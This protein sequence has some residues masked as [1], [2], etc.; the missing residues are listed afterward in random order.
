[1]DAMPDSPA[2]ARLAN[3]PDNGVMTLDIVYSFYS[4]INSLFQIIISSYYYKI[5]IRN[6]TGAATLP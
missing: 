6:A 3:I 4:S 1:V 2:K 5:D